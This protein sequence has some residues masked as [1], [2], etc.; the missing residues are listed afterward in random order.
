MASVVPA[1]HS[2]AVHGAPS[3]RIDTAVPAPNYALTADANDLAQLSDGL[4][5]EF[6]QWTKRGSVG[7]SQ[8]TPVLLKGRLLPRPGP[9]TASKQLRVSSARQTASDVLPP[10]RIDVY[11]SGDGISWTHGGVVAPASPSTPDGARVTLSGSLSVRCIDQIALVVHGNGPYLMLDELEVKAGGTAP[12]QAPE[13][14]RGIKSDDLV[15]DSLRRLTGEIQGAAARRLA[16][17]VNAPRPDEYAAWMAAPWGSLGVES[18]SAE[19]LGQKVLQIKAPQGWPAQYA[20]G[21]L[22]AGTVERTYRISTGDQAP[23]EMFRIAPIIAASGDVVFDPLERL[24]GVS[25]VLPP[26]S[27]GYVLVRSAAVR[28]S[29]RIGVEVRT[30]DGWGQELSLDIDS[31][32]L[33]SADRSIPPDVITWS[34]LA[35]DPI[36]KARNQ[37]QLIAFQRD[38]GVNVFVIHPRSI[39]VP[40]VEGD[41]AR[42][43]RLLRDELRAYKGARTVL[44]Y[45]SWNAQIEPTRWSSEDLRREIEGWLSRLSTVMASEGY[46]YDD[47]AIYPADEPAG[48]TLEFVARVA[49]WMKAR[50]KRVRV[51]ANPGAVD[52]LDLLPGGAVRSALDV[53]DLWQPLL[54]PAADRLGPVLR[55]RGNGRWSVYSVGT[56]PAKTA[57]PNCYRKVAWEAQQ[58]GA[59]GLGFWS[60]SDT[61]G[62]SAW[63]DLDGARADWAVV[64]EADSGVVS[65]RRWEAFRQGVMEY[66]ILADCALAGA[67]APQARSCEAFRRSIDL[68]LGG[69]QCR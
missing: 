21:L 69:L 6:P 18:L 4:Q 23:G 11:C 1:I 13:D 19:R 44:L 66:R 37:E 42:K 14:A 67:N 68:E 32:P 31:L 29:A 28:A 41:W 54:G 55:Q 38:A 47:W 30:D 16:S 51:Y 26:R 36:W 46:E 57:V 25:I 15:A 34:Y 24:P 45:V 65:S 17:F 12:A 40:G 43:E 59:T 61:G 9:A 60:F 64:Y 10:K 48:E 2:E 20:I 62:S 33:L 7:W 50:D 8:V 52:V 49:A 22:N 63:D 5:M 58:L 3:L 53:V 35:D 56:A 27:I 39:P